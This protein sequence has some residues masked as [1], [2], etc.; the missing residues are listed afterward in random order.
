M[1]RDINSTDDYKMK[2]PPILL[3]LW[4]KNTKDSN[5]NKYFIYTQNL[6]SE[7]ENLLAP[8]LGSTD[9]FQKI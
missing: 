9:I 5:T 3:N 2:N 1:L 6:K 7:E 8:P 4:K